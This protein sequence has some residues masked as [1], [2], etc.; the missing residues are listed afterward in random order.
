MSKLALVYI[1]GP[2]RGKTAYQVRLNI[3][4]A[5]AAALRVWKCGM[6]AI[7][8]HLNTANF[9]GELPDQAFLDGDLAILSR[10][11]AV[12]LTSEWKRSAGAISEYEYAQ[13]N[14]IPVFHNI[15]DLTARLWGSEFSRNGQ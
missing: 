5:E 15:G 14:D 8:P 3:R 9:T 11:D 2:F 13:E 6:V 12:L 1:A 10:C 4:E 7:C